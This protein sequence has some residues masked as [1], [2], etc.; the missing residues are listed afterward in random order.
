V[1]LKELKVSFEIPVFFSTPC[2][3]KLQQERSYSPPLPPPPFFFDQERA[4]KEA[5]GSVA[6]LPLEESSTA[7]VRFLLPD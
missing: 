3:F 2:E 4:L 1:A 7:N 6:S 5:S